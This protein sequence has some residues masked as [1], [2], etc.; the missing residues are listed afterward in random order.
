[1]LTGICRAGGWIWYNTEVRNVIIG[2]KTC[3][4][5]QADFEKAY[6]Q[7]EKQPQPRVK[8]VRYAIDIFPESRNMTMRGEQVIFNPYRQQPLNEVHFTLDPDYDYRNRD[9][10]LLWQKTTRISFTVSIVLTPP[11]QPGENRTMRFTVKSH[12]RGFENEVSNLSTGPE[13]DIF[14]QHDRAAH[15]L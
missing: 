7:F 1:M 15:W 8:D 4:R 12:T 6:K 11:L 10:G 14:Q 2:P 9:T 5:R 3:E 13:W